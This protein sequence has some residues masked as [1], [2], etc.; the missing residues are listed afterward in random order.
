MS[1]LEFTDVLVPT[2]GS[3]TADAALGTALSLASH[4]GARVHVLSVV[5]PY[6]LSKVT[7]VEARRSEAEE[8]VEGAADRAREAGVP[9]ETAV[10]VG[11]PHEAIAGYVTDHGVD[12][13]VMGTHGRTGVGRALMGS[14]TEK[15]VRTV[16]VP[17]LTV[18]EEGP[19]FEPSRVLLATDGSGPAARAERVGLA[20]A[21]EF[22]ATVEAVSVVDTAPLTAGSDPV[23]QGTRAL[24]DVREALTEGAEDAVA[25]VE[26]DGEAAGVTV[27][28]T[29]GEGRPHERILAAARE[30]DAD[31]IVIGTHGR[32]GFERFVLG[33]VAEKVLRLSDRPVLVVPSDGT[34]SGA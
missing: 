8:T 15:T 33:S 32:G 5:N 25:T 31:V 18:H 14:V 4:V 23:G 20:L 10:S 16:R 19:R 28:T 26:A 7:D 27:E 2:D 6:V 30:R 11:A 34:D 17:V 12:V 24:Q 21:G 22:G 29:V 9:V 3:E 1:T 13:V